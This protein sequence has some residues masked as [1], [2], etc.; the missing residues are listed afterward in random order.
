MKYNSKILI[1]CYVRQLIA[2][3]L[4]LCSVSAAHAN[5]QQQYYISQA[6]GRYFQLPI[7][8]R[9]LSVSSGDG[10]LCR[11]SVCNYLN[12]AGLG[13]SRRNELGITISDRSIGGD[14]FTNADQ[15][16]QSEGSGY[17]VGAFP[18]GDSEHSSPE[19]GSLG[20]GFSRYQGDTDDPIN[21]TPDGHR[22]TFAY[23][24]A[25][26]EQ[27]SLGYSFTFFDDQLKSDLADIHSHSRFLHLFG[28]QT[29]LGNG[30]S[31]G[32]VFQL[33]IGQSDTEDFVFRSD[34]LSKL[35]QYT[36]SLSLKKTWERTNLSIF[37]D[38]TDLHSRG[39]L[40]QASSAVVIG[41]SE[42]GQIFNF[43][44]GSETRVIDQLY[45]RFGS[46]VF[47]GH[48]KF[49]RPDLMNLSGNLN[50]YGFSTGMGYDFDIDCNNLKVDYGVE[51]LTVA[52][53]EWQHI[54]SLAFLF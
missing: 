1:F 7:D 22:R 27:F 11:G 43:S 2:T 52:R 15:I 12:P 39:N 46:R 14:D 10:L 23:G 8:A 24:Y 53:G 16:E 32:G 38:F 13:F 45:A 51:Y 6:L 4:F 34:G 30:Y 41:G 42:Q 26:T 47:S 5:P 3:C 19:Y 9:T 21:S 29:E 25:P 17:I 40:D 35:R 36:Y 54:L 20:L 50:G 37:S 48:Y 31:L 28:L 33:G 18:L 44:L 49:L